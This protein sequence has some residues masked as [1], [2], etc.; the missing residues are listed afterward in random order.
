[1]VKMLLLS[2]LRGAG[3]PVKRLVTSAGRCK[4]G[5]TSCAV[6]KNVLLCHGGKHQEIHNPC[7]GV[8][9]ARRTLSHSQAE[10]VWKSLKIVSSTLGQL[11]NRIQEETN[12]PLPSTDLKKVS[13]IPLP[14]NWLPSYNQKRSF[15]HGLFDNGRQD[16]LTYLNRSLGPLSYNCRGLHLEP[17]RY[18]KIPTTF[19]VPEV[20]DQALGT[21]FTPQLCAESQHRI[22]KI[23][24]EHL[25]KAL[26]SNKVKVVKHQ[27][28]DY[29]DR[30]LFKSPLVIQVEKDKKF[31][32]AAF[33][34]PAVLRYMIM[35]ITK[36]NLDTPG[37]F[38]ISGD[39]N[40]VAKLKSQLEQTFYGSGSFDGSKYTIH[41]YTTLLKDYLRELPARLI[42]TEKFE[43]FPDIEDLDFETQQIPI[44]RFFN[45]SMIREHRNTVWYL[46]SFL[47]E[48]AE[49][50][51]KNQMDADKL[52]VFFG[53]ILFKMLD[54]PAKDVGDK[55]SCHVNLARAW[56][57]YFRNLAL[58]PSDIM[59]E[60][61]KSFKSKP[62]DV[63]FNPKLFPQKPKP[64]SVP[65][66]LQNLASAKITVLTPYED[67]PS[68]E[69]TIG[70]QHVAK[71]VVCE[72][73]GVAF[74][75]FEV[76]G[77]DSASDTTSLLKP[78]VLHDL[79]TDEPEDD[80]TKYKGEY[81]QFLYE[82]GGNMGERCLNSNTKMLDLY[83]A[84]PKAFWVVK[85]R[86]APSM[87]RYSHI[88]KRDLP[89]L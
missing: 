88:V 19:N 5:F 58:V 42:S 67:Q 60:V 70:A 14:L 53:P 68:K 89:P 34:V 15:H 55:V 4:K 61:R 66:D 80:D 81:A 11:N 76:K 27:P 83:K 51:D 29:P 12:E 37:L 48:V 22:K 17:A 47:E 2:S 73:L 69:I 18:C 45:L 84:N 50:K 75:P 3:A 41:D 25:K 79:G 8:L 28:K 71:Q 20:P 62:A 35:E 87:I 21:T 46:L 72:A 85:S 43:V 82:I 9:L 44:M 86:Q 57:F 65:K 23:A 63:K 36:R 7:N 31:K 6:N 77:N 78:D 56:M 16:V 54:M 10:N 24:H 64:P 74:D 26:R 32:K 30:G 1:M 13:S 40:N 49:H 33:Q 39:P 38:K 52:A 59:D